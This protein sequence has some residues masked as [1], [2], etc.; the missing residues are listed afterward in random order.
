MKSIYLRLLELSESHPDIVLAIITESTGSTP[1]KPGSAALFDR[2]GLL[3]GTVGG[4]ILEGKVQALAINAISSGEIQ[5]ITFYLNREL[6]KGE[7]AICGG[8][9]SVLIDPN[10]LYHILIFTEIRNCLAMKTPGILVTKINDNPGGRVTLERTWITG[11]KKMASILPAEADN[12]AREI[13]EKGDPSYFRKIESAANGQEVTDFYFLEP[14][15]PLPSLVIAGAGHIGKALAHIG[16]LLE[17]EVTVIDERPDLANNVNI[18]EA[19]NIIVEEPGAALKNVNLADTYVVIVTRGHKDDE[20][21]LKACIGSKA[22]YIGMIGSRSKV[23]IMKRNFLS[24]GWAT[25]EQWS[26]INAPIGL[27]IGSK[28]VQEI[29]VSI[30]AELVRIRRKER[31]EA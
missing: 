12:E 4:G 14:V 15:F 17:F 11:E 25:E 24:T 10:P 2:S 1:Q 8:Q 28:T 13:L 3:D 9:V 16:S 19:E 7:D 22:S 27:D 23:E 26:R 18:P 21:A 6:S 5:H 30:A 29:A 20:S 31:R